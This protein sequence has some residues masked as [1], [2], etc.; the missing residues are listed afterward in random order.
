M[1]KIEDMCPVPESFQY[2][3]RLGDHFI[4]TFNQKRWIQVALKTAKGLQLFGR[5]LQINIKIDTDGIQAGFPEIVFIKISNPLGESD[6]G[7][8]WGFFLI[9]SMIFLVGFIHQV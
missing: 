7:N 6:Q 4:S 2:L 9:W 3:F 5:P 1:T 8:I